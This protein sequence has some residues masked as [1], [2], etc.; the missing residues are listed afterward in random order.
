M[1]LHVIL[2]VL[3]VLSTYFVGVQGNNGYIAGLYYSVSIMAILLAHEMGHYLMSRKYG[4]PS[5]LPYFIPFPLPPFGTLGAIIKMK[6]VITNKKAL[7]DVGVAG[8]LSG[9]IVALP[10]VYFGLDLS[11]IGPANP[12]S[13]LRLGDPLLF[14]ILEWIMIGP[15]PPHRD[16]YLHP[17]AYAGWAGLFVTALNLLPVGQ[18]DGG[19]IVYSV[20]GEKSRPIF[21]LAIAALAVLALFKNPGWLV[22]IIL[23]IIFGMRHPKPHDLDTPLD[24]KRKTLAIVMLLIFIL[25]FVPVPFPDINL[26]DALRGLFASPKRGV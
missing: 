8:P 16:I 14:K 10:C 5:S 3:T 7:F 20:F 26:W 25:S 23:L 13:A 12:P 9:F 18:L 21:I 22:L 17:M 6:G 15:L 24:G 4:I 1:A 11:L 19:H 2:F